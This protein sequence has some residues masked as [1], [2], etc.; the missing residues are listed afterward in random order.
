MSAT[1]GTSGF[2]TL[3]Q[4]GDGGVGAGVKASKTIGTVNQQLKVLAKVAGTAGNSKTFGIVVS[5]NSTAYSQVIT[6][7][8]VLIN[9]ATDSMGAATTTVLQAIANL[10]AS[11]TFDAAFDATVGTGDG[12]GILVAGASGVLSSGA[13]GTEAF[14][15]V[16][17]I[18]NISG[19]GIKL[20]LI[21]ATHMESPDAFREFIPSL[22]DGTEV[23]FDLNYLPGDTNQ[24]G[25]RDDQL[26]RA[27]R[28]YRIVWT[29]ED[30]STDQF[31]GYVTDFTPSAKIDD[32]LSASATLKITGPIT[33][34]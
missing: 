25:L 11:A 32:K 30:S 21:D 18:T 4:R 2:G 9:S 17:E 26:D 29:D 33:R 6:S 24:G 16:A 14:T 20:E 1:Q 28:N 13:E 19:P 34:L 7:T 15:T 27:V 5:G 8:S 10:Y 22:L 31:A 23:S 3:L 12:S